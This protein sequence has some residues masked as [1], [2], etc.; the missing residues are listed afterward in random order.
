V[1]ERLDLQDAGVRWPGLYRAAGRIATRLLLLANDVT[2]LL[3][4]FRTELLNIMERRPDKFTFVPRHF[5][6]PFAC[7]QRS[8]RT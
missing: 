7:G 6:R 8:T 3:P 2:V 4:S 5:Q 1:F